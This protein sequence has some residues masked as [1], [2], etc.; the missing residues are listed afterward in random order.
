MNESKGCPGTPRN[1]ADLA[2]DESSFS[3]FK[4]NSEFPAKCHNNEYTVWGFHNL[5]E[6]VDLKA[7]Q[8]LIENTAMINSNSEMYTCAKTAQAIGE[9]LELESVTPVSTKTLK[10]PKR[11][12]L[13]LRSDV[14]NKSSLRKLRKLILGVFKE[15]NKKLLRR[16]L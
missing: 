7:E 15:K 2:L 10:Y 6:E 16:K 13:E 9:P 1:C 3:E 4:S 14:L 12:N 11:K 5:N 8:V